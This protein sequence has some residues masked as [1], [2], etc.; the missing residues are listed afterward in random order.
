MSKYCT[1]AQFKAYFPVSLVGT[2]DDTVLQNALDL[3]EGEFERLA[4]SQFNQQTLTNEFPLRAWT[5]RNGMVVL[6]AK[7]AA[8]ITAVSSVQYLLPPNRTWQTISW[9]S[10]G[11]FLPSNDAPPRPEAWKVEIL[12]SSPAM[13]QWPTD[14]I[15]FRWTYTAGYS[16]TPTALQLLIQRFATYEYAMRE[17]PMGKILV[18]PMSPMPSVSDLPADLK[19]DIRLWTRPMG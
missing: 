4:G 3:A 9:D 15:R 14:D 8:P 1:L 2:G 16:V 19:K 11:L 10:D 13:G 5:D 6:S 12:P 17:A 18:Q 7:A